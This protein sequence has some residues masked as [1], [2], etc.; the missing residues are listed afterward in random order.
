[1]PDPL[2]V[3]AA[4]LPDKFPFGFLKKVYS[5]FMQNLVMWV[6]IANSVIL[7]L[8]TSSAVAGSYGK[9]LELLDRICL[10]VFCVELAMK[11]LCERLSFFKSGWNVFDFLIVGISVVPGAGKYSVLRALRILRAM[12]LITKLPRLRVIVESIVRSLPGIG[13]ISVLLIIIFYIFAVLSTT[14]YGKGFP[15]WFGT[16]GKSMYSLFQILTLESWSMGI[17]RPIMQEF[18]YAY[19][20]FVPFILVSSFVVLNVFIGVIVNAIGEVSSERADERD[21]TLKAE[22]EAELEAE[23]KAE[24]KAEIEAEI[25]PGRANEPLSALAQAQDDASVLASFR[26]EIRSLRS[27]LERVEQLLEKRGQAQ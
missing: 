1:M 12:R 16:L 11:L 8:E 9:I 17:V 2:P 10:A 18:P 27:Q 21:A 25:H 24:V 14:L 5:P 13:W 3:S 4:R 7:G 15:D 20:V 6:I 22:L 23:V 19:L 26:E